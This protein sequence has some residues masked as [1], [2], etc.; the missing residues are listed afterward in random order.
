MGMFT[1]RWLVR[2]YLSPP[3]V[4]HIE[5]YTK[6]I[7]NPIELEKPG[8]YNDKEIISLND[9]KIAMEKQRPVYS[10][11]RDFH[12]VS[13]QVFNT[14]SWRNLLIF[15]N[16]LASFLCL[17]VSIFVIHRIF[18]INAMLAILTASPI[19]VKSLVYESVDHTM[20]TP[21]APEKLLM[22]SPHALEITLTVIIITWTIIRLIQQIYKAKLRPRIAVE[23][24]NGHQDI[25]IPFHYLNECGIF[26]HVIGDN[27]IID[28]NV[29]GYILPRVRLVVG[30]LKV[31]SLVSE[32]IEPLYSV[33]RINILKA[34]KMRKILKGP[35][36]TSLVLLDDDTKYYI[37]I[38]P[39][40]CNSCEAKLNYLN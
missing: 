20:R 28:V 24:S 5:D 34:F 19:R 21:I 1:G 18:K 32:G 33:A 25:T 26:C 4:V 17:T 8:L 12:E 16:T 36:F 22:C 3:P 9:L 7:E 37:K 15:I 30:N 10:F 31:S 13:D 35:F 11:N 40:D 29:F 23:L 14:F 27:N 39:S 38:C 6:A 2:Q